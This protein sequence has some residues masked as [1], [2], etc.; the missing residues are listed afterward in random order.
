MMVLYWLHQGWE[1][2]CQLE[3]IY[4]S[5]SSDLKLTVSIAKTKHM[6]SRR[7]VEDCEGEVMLMDGM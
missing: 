4:P 5:T 6:V 1:W 2:S 3:S 7:T